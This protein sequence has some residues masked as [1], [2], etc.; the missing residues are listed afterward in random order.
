MHIDHLMIRTVDLK[1]CVD[2]Y[3]RHLPF[4]LVENSFSGEGATL[5]GENLELI[6]I[7]IE[8]GQLPNPYHFALAAKSK[9]H[10]LEL[11]QYFKAQG[12]HPRKQPQLDS[13]RT[14]GD[15]GHILN[16]YVDDPSGI[17]VEITFRPAD[18]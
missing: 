6:L 15:Y 5:Q 17:K 7:P 4:N 14:Y 10:F 3:T 13:E 16:F 12:L 8:K 9:N 11:Y 2:F 1:S 18:R